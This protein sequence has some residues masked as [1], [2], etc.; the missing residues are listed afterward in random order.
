[1][2]IINAYSWRG[3]RFAGSDVMSAPYLFIYLIK[4]IVHTEL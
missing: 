1:M 4:F 3:K 2:L